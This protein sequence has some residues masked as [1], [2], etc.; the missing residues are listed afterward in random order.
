MI[1]PG[2]TRAATHLPSPGSAAEQAGAQQ[3][4]DTCRTPSPSLLHVLL[5]A[6]MTLR[7]GTAAGPGQIATAAAMSFFEHVSVGDLNRH[8]PSTAWRNTL[9]YFS[10][11]V[12]AVRHAALALAL[13]QR[14][15]HAP[16]RLNSARP[17]GIDDGSALSHYNRAI[18]LLLAYNQHYSSDKDTEATAVTLLAC[19]LFICFDHLAG[20]Q[21]QSS[22]HLRGGIEL[23]RHEFRKIGSTSSRPVD[24]YHYRQGVSSV[25]SLLAQVTRQFRRLDLQI[26]TYAVDWVP[27]DLETPQTPALPGPSPLIQ[28]DPYGSSHGESAFRSLDYAADE[29]QVL[30]AKA[31][32]LRVVTGR[33]SLLPEAQMPCPIQISVLKTE[34]EGWLARFE[35]MPLEAA[36]TIETRRIADL[37]RLQYTLVWVHLC[38]HGP[39]WEMEYDRFLPEF[40]RCVA[41]ADSIVAAYDDDFSVL[42]PSV[43]TPELGIVPV[44]YMVGAKCRHPKI[45]REAVRVL[46]WRH[47]REAV[48]DSLITARVVELM[49]EVEEEE[50]GSGAISEDAADIARI[51]V[52]RR[53]E[54]MTYAEMRGVDAARTWLDVSFSFCGSEEVLHRE[55]FM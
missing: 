47:V 33:W 42:L 41:L 28:Y 3:L 22:R 40:V 7:D 1:P 54:T 25:K 43:F 34:L 20:N 9:L 5:P 15:H 8:N 10:Q 21:V 24:S 27:L 26:A 4:Q 13:I 36:A 19:Y 48:W 29:L 52:R 50:A 55:V 30:L 6:F 11:T 37:L 44:L 39:S 35:R 18:Q 51:P 32:K 16:A 53:I 23:L 14:G 12:P 46:R 38:S 17:R 31:M 2:A 49:I 45:R